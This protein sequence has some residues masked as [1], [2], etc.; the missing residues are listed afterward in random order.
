M[1]KFLNL[2]FGT[3]DLPTYLAGL[4]FAII[5]LAFYYKGKVAARNKHS[6]NT[7]YY[8]SWSFFTQD[9]LMELV[10][11][12]LAIFLALRF[13]VE[14]A[15]VQVTMFYSLGIGWGLPKFISYMYSIQDNARNKLKRKSL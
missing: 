8:F 6:Y 9:N 12:V 15:G 7:P 4:F 5:G 13:S 2:I 11:S 10:F 1:N 14:Y 3:T